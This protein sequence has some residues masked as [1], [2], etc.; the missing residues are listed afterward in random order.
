MAFDIT[1]GKAVLYGGQPGNLQTWF[2][3]TWEFGGVVAASFVGHGA[4][5]V[6]ERADGV[7]F[8]VAVAQA[9]ADAVAAD[10]MH[11]ALDRA[12][13]GVA[14]V[15]AGA[16]VVGHDDDLAGVGGEGDAA[17]VLGDHGGGARAAHRVAVE[18]AQQERFERGGEGR[19]DGGVAFELASH[20]GEHRAVGEG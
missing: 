9:Q 17:Q 16:V 14:Q 18:A 4:A 15:D 11:E 8:G 10:G 13:D 19:V 5:G 12:D 6:G 2:D 20:G 3:E 7:V 1:R